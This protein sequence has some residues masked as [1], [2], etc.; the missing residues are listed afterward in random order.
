MHERPF[1][2]LTVASDGGGGVDPDNRDV[3]VGNDR[4]DVEFC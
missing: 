4:A 3:T 2:G 1:D